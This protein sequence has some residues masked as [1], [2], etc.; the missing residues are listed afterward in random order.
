MKDW[1]RIGLCTLMLPIKC[2]VQ[3]FTNLVQKIKLTY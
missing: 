2:P 3:L 1:V